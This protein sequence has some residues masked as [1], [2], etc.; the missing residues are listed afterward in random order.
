M[1]VSE[2]AQG[3]ECPGPGLVKVDFYGDGKPTFA[4]V[5]TTRSVAKG[6]NE[7]VLAHQAGTI[8]KT[9]TLQATDGDAPVV[10]SE[11]TGEYKD[12]YDD[13]RSKRPDRSSFLPV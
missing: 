4:L 9:I 1:V 8:W 10:W 5:L 6:R 3:N 12:V 2:R 7:L 13:R 11:K